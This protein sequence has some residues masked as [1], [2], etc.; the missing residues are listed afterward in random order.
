[1]ARRP[2]EAHPGGG[3]QAHARWGETWIDVVAGAV[4]GRRVALPARPGV[5]LPLDRAI[6]R[7]A[8]EGVAVPVLAPE[9]VLLFKATTGDRSTPRPKDDADL[10]QALPSLDRDAR[11]WLH[12]ALPAD[13]PWRD[14]LTPGA[15]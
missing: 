12:A 4:D 8:V 7:V 11:A 10:A 2:G 13:H 5:T 9:A 6:R 15:S 1:V 3:H 14:R